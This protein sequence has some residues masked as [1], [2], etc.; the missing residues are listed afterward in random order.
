MGRI[1]NSC[2]KKEGE[3]FVGRFDY[4]GVS[5][6]FRSPR[7]AGSVR[8]ICKGW[9][10]CSSRRNEQALRSIDFRAYDGMCGLTLTV[11]QV[12]SVKDWK[13]MRKM[14]FKCVDGKGLIIMHLWKVSLG[15]NFRIFIF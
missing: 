4:S 10:L 8:G 3:V 12:P 6:S 13:H 9:S 14:I 15:R 11:P 1:T 2:L 5:V 7:V